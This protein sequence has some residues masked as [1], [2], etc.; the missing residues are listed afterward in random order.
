[1]IDVLIQ[2]AIAE[3]R[4]LPICARSERPWLGPVGNRTGMT[5]WHS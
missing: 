5:I 3:K 2:L 1:M 4:P